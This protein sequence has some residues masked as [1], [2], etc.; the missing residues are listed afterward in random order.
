MSEAL[1]KA[2][3]YIMSK[4]GKKDFLRFVRKRIKL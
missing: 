2:C 1:K 3:K 4:K